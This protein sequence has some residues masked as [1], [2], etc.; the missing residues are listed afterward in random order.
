MKCIICNKQ[1]NRT[2]ILK[3]HINRYHDIDK[4]TNEENY[5]K[6]QINPNNIDFEKVIELYKEGYTVNDL[7]E[8]YGV[9]FSKYIEVL[10]IKR[11]AS[12]SKKT[13]IYKNRVENTNLKRHGVKNPSQSEDIKKKKKETFIKNFGYENNFCNSTIR[14]KA[15]SNIDYDK[16]LLST[17]SSLIRKYGPN[18]QNSAQIPGVGK[19]IGDSNRKRISKMSKEQRRKLTEKSKGKY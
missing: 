15:L 5:I 3:I 7:K 18:V 11:T 10:G 8:R 4:I 2:N 12:E 14:K 9:S 1:F 17:K 6:S 19:K 13:K 16:V